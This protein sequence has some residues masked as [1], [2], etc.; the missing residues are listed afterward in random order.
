[1]DQTTGFSGGSIGVPISPLHY[2]DQDRECQ[3][4]NP[5]VGA[6]VWES[7]RIIRVTLAQIGNGLDLPPR[8]FY[9]GAASIRDLAGNPVDC[10]RRF[11]VT[12]L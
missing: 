4:D 2:V 1:M 5:G 6:G 11:P 10:F 12:V 7:A 8:V 3:V 9:N